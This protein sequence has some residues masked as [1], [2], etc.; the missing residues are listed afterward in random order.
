[1]AK[2]LVTGGAGF[3]GTNLVKELLLQKHEVVVLDNFACGKK[4]ERIQSGATYIEADVL[5]F[6]AVLQAMDGVD[7]VFHLATLPRVLFSVEN[8]LLTHD[9]NVNGTL[10][11]LLATRDRGIKRVVFSSS[12]STYGDQ[13]KIPFVEDKMVKQPLAP[14]PLHKLIGEHYCRIFASLYGLETVSLIYFNVY[15]P[16]SDPHDAYAL[17][18]SRF[19]QQKKNNEP[20]TIRGDGEMYRDYTHVL[21]VV[22][23]NILAMTKDSVGKGETIN[24]GFGKPY[25]VNQ[26]AQLIGGDIK[27]IP[28]VAGEISYT[29]AD[30]RKAKRLLGWSPKINL[31]DGIKMLKEELGLD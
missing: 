2:Y 8:P 27:Y 4:Q 18:I 20:L 1:M 17:V 31:E 26:L 7:G 22:E 30:N 6:E 21:D 25:S 9:V 5:D 15:G 28:S 29:H 23:A 10:N 3:I 11:V 16:Y 12:S 13:G 19:L 24:I 14:Y